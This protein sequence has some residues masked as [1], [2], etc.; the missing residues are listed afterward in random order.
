[1]VGSREDRDSW[2][3]RQ[4]A[5]RTFAPGKNSGLSQAGVRACICMYSCTLTL[6]CA[7]EGSLGGSLPT[8]RTR[9]AHSGGAT[10]PTLTSGS[11]SSFTCSVMFLGHF[12]F[13]RKCSHTVC[14][15]KNGMP[16]LSV[17][18]AANLP[19]SAGLVQ[20]LTRRWLCALLSLPLGALDGPNSPFY[21]WVSWGQDLNLGLPVPSAPTSAGDIRPQEHAPSLWRSSQGKSSINTKESQ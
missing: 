19:L 16:F 9:L 15:T 3:Q 11:G 7:W 6:V 8:H 5:R 1:M 14:P 21:R 4:E 10:V 12:C 17:R 13:W 20:S 2:G 18:I